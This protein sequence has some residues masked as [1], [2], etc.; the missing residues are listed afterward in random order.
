MVWIRDRDPK[1]SGLPTYN[2][3]KSQ[4]QFT[5]VRH[6]HRTMYFRHH[7]IKQLIACK[8]YRMLGVKGLAGKIK[9]LKND[10][11]TSS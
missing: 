4:R 9:E 1:D 10:L 7:R 11:N 6:L 5:E 3:F 8:Y 2:V